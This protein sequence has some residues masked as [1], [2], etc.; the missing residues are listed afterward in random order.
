MYRFGGSQ[1]VQHCQQCH[2]NKPGALRGDLAMPWTVQSSSNSGSH[3]LCLD[4]GASSRV[5]QSWGQAAPGTLSLSFWK[6]MTHKLMN[7]PPMANLCKKSPRHS[8]KT[9]DLRGLACNLQGSM[10]CFS[11]ID[12]GSNKSSSCKSLFPSVCGHWDEELVWKISLAKREASWLGLLW[13]GS[14]AWNGLSPHH[15][16]LIWWLSRTKPLA[17][18]TSGY[19]FWWSQTPCFLDRPPRHYGSVAVWF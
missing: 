9:F 1:T 3:T 10:S 18:D 5:P 11:W 17:K 2:H 6:P 13:S 7:H 19:S 8:L 15:T 16:E 12:C 14:E 4:A